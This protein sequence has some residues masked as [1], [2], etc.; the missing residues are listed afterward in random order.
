[1]QFSLVIPSIQSML[2]LWRTFI[3]ERQGWPQAVKWSEEMW[4]S[5]EDQG[6]SLIKHN[7]SDGE[8]WRALNSRPSYKEGCLEGNAHGES[9]RHQRH[10]AHS[11]NGAGRKS[12]K[13]GDLFSVLRSITRW[14]MWWWSS[15]K[16]TGRF[17]TMWQELAEV[18]SKKKNKRYQKKE[19]GQNEKR[20]ISL[21]A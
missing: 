5:E 17:F 14:E 1:M 4:C 13:E 20:Q 8:S 11:S 19:K 6:N 15:R 2:Y 18:T 3:S 10:E 7:R 16:W 21:Q 9:G 12:W